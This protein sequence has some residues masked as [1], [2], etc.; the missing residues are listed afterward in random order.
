MPGTEKN[1]SLIKGSDFD[2]DVKGIVNKHISADLPT[3]VQFFLLRGMNLYQKYD[4]PTYDQWKMEYRDIIEP[5]ISFP[6]KKRGAFEK[7]SSF[8]VQCRAELDDI[9]RKENYQEL[10]N[11]FEAIPYHLPLT[12]DD[13]IKGNIFKKEV[14]S[15]VIIF[16]GERAMPK[17][18]KGLRY[19]HHLIKNQGKGISASDLRSVVDKPMPV[20]HL[21]EN[22]LKTEQGLTISNMASLET[23]G[24][25]VAIKACKKKIKELKAEIAKCERD[26]TPRLEKDRAELEAVEDYLGKYLS[27]NGRLRRAGSKS[28]TD[29][30]V[31]SA[32]ITRTLTKIKKSKNTYRHLKAFI[33]LG[34]ECVYKPDQPV[35]WHL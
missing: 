4:E 26:G 18:C 5:L 20:E 31:V 16:E 19:I 28:D 29:R 11:Y 9:K 6:D 33:N 21:Y 8:I 27:K 34:Y 32:D 2:W 14:D 1:E 15:W 25:N 10:I 12:Q 7:V 35:D 3:E 17:D 30:K 13:K 23:V 22:S 24:D